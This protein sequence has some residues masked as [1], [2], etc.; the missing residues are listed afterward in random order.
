MDLKKLRERAEARAV[1]PRH[2]L[3]VLTPDEIAKLIHELDV[4][5]IELELQNK[6]LQQALERLEITNA[7]Y[8]DLYNLAPVGYCTLNDKGLINE[9]NLTF[10]DMVGSPRN[11]LAK[12]PFTRYILPSHQD[13]FYHFFNQLHKSESPQS[14]SIMMNCRK[15]DSLWIRLDAFR[16]RES[17]E[18]QGDCKITVTDINEQKNLERELLKH[19]EYIRIIL[20][21]T[22]NGILVIDNSGKVITKNSRFIELWRIPEVLQKFSDD[23]NLLEYVLGQLISPEEFLVEVHK[24]YK[25][26][27]FSNDEIYFIDGRVYERYS[28]PLII[29]QLNEG[30]IWSFRDA[31]NRINAEKEIRLKNDE[32]VKTNAE[33]DKFFSIIAHDL[34]SPFNS[35]LGFTQLLSEDVGTMS[36]YEIQKIAANMRA[37]ANNLFELLENLLEWSKIKRGVSSF[38]PDSFRLK[39]FMTDELQSIV[40]MANK[41]EIEF[42]EEVGEEVEVYADRNMLG[43]IMRNLTTNAVKFT[44]KGGKISISSKYTSGS[45]VEIAVSD[46]GIGM[47]PEILSKLFRTDVL[48]NRNG[49]ENEKSNGLGLILCKEFITKQGGNIRV[50]SNEGQGSTFYITLP[51]KPKN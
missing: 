15:K 46:N 16:T 45:S 44:T 49:T 37:S 28:A 23:K 27:S 42:S 4:H 41:K 29:N 6:E 11:K 2:H 21:S 1:E 24:L 8:F 34:R 50:E 20:E 32:L 33:K 17:E 9:A 51:P 35:F 26:D 3:S 13:T 40:V 22:D 30:R 25:S 12:T 7:R 43:S 47:N 39:P 38:E 19:E 18:K 5:Q 48:T 31:T 10:A 36:L 14:C